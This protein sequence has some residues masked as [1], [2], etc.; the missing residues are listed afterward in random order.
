MLRCQAGGY[1]DYEGVRPPLVEDKLYSCNHL[2]YVGT[3]V[4]FSHKL[5]C[6]PPSSW[7]NTMHRNGVKVLGTFIVES[8]KIQPGRMLDQ[9]DGEFVVAKQLAAIAGAFGFDG[10][11]LNVEIEFPNLVTHPTEKLTGFIRSLKRLL[12]SEG[13]VIW[14]D[15]L[16]I[17]N[18]VDYQNGLTEKNVPFALAADYLF[19]NYKWTKS[20]LEQA[21]IVSQWHGITPKEVQFGIDVWAQNTDMPGPPRVTFPAKVGGGTNTGLVSLNTLNCMF[22]HL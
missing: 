13:L 19:T 20:K 5:V 12:G 18:R 1:R 9:E 4:Y 7:T 17:D 10:W 2:Q 3:F 21:K 16:N 14:Y 22:L 8:E 15:A 11:L 6:V